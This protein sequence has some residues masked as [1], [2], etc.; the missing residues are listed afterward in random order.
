LPGDF[1][2]DYLGENGIGARILYEENPPYV[3]SY[4]VESRLIFFTIA[5]IGSIT[6]F[7]VKFSLITE[8]LLSGTILMSFAVGYFGPA[9]KRTGYDGVI[10]FGR[11]GKSCK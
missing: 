11:N 4:S 7:C 2:T 3:D 10:N 5:R 1:A 9:F 6:P 8:S